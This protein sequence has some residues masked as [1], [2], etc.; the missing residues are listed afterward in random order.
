MSHGRKLV[1]RGTVLVD[2]RAAVAKLRSYQL[3]EPV[4][5]VLELVRAAVAGGATAIE[6]ENDADD[7]ALTF[8]G[9]AL[10]AEDLSRLLDFLLSES[11]RRLRLVAV[12]VNTALGFSPR[13]VD[14]YTT[15]FEGAPADASTVARVR[16]SPRAQPDAS[17]DQGVITRVA[18]P[19]GMPAAGMR[20][21]VREA[22]G[23]A[24]LREWFRAAPAETDLLR[25]RVVALPVPLTRN[26]VALTSRDAK[27][28]LASVA[29]EL[30]G[31]LRGTLEL[32]EVGH[33]RS[34][35]LVFCERGVALEIVP[36]REA[37]PKVGAP[38]LRM[39]VDADALPTNAS[40]SKVTLSAGLRGATRRAWEVAVTALIEGAIAH[41]DDRSTAIAESLAALLRF[42]A[43]EQWTS[44]SP[45]S[46]SEESEAVGAL[47]VAAVAMLLNAPIVPVANG[48]R[49][50]LRELIA[51][52]PRYLWNSAKPPPEE[53]SPWLRGVVWVRGERP[54]LMALLAAVEMEPASSAI[55]RAKEARSRHQRFM[56]LPAGDPVNE[57]RE[58]AIRLSFGEVGRARGE[59]TITAKGLAKP[60]AMRVV[61]WI[62]RRP[63][64]AE[65]LDGSPVAC[66]VA[67]EAPGLRAK[68]EFD[69]VVRDAA[70][71]DAV[72]LLRDLL[73]E[74][75][76]ALVDH[77][78]GA[79]RA[80]D[81]RSAWIGTFAD[82]VAPA[83]RARVV[84]AAWAVALSRVEPAKRRA[85][86]T[87]VIEKHPRLDTAP[88]WPT[89]SPD[90]TLDT[91]TVRKLAS[92]P[93]SVILSAPLLSTGAHP[94]GTPVLTLDGDDRAT[95]TQLV[96]QRVEW[97]DY[98][99]FL[100]PIA[101]RPL[102]EMLS[103]ESLATLPWV[104]L[105]RD[106]AR[107]A[108]APAPQAGRGA[109]TLVHA[110][111]VLESRAHTTTISRF[112]LTT[113]LAPALVVLE[114]DGI[115]PSPKGNG[116]VAGTLSVEAQELLDRAGAALARGL[117]AALRGERGSPKLGDDARV[118]LSALRFILR[119]LKAT[120]GAADHRDLGDAITSAPL[121]P[122]FG[123]GDVETLVS[124]NALTDRYAAGKGPLPS[125]ATTPTGVDGAGF[126]AIILPPDIASAFSAAT[127]VPLVDASSQLPHRKG[128]RSRRLAREALLAR[129]KTNLDALSSLGAAGPVATASLDRAGSVAMAP[130]NG[131]SATRVQV[132]FNDV[133]AI[134]RA[135]VR[136]SYPVVARVA[137]SQ[138]RHLR[139]SFDSLTTAGVQAVEKLLEAGAHALASRLAAAAHEG[140]VG[141]ASRQFLTSWVGLKGRRGL[142]EDPTLQLALAR[143]PL[144]RTPTGERVALEGIAP[145]ISC[146]RVT[147]GE[148]LGP[149]PGEP[150]DPVYLC[151]ADEAWVKCIASISAAA[152]R[153]VTQAALTSQR[154]RRLRARGTERIHLDGAPPAP[155][156]SGRIESLA[157]SLGFGELRIVEGAPGVEVSVFVEGR[158][159]HRTTLRAPFAMA[160]AIECA[161]IDPARVNESFL[162]LDPV[163]KLL[164]AARAL[165]E[166]AAAMT[167]D[168]IPAWAQ[169]CLRW[170]LL[171]TPGHDA[172]ARAAAAF[173]DSA[174]R[175]M[176]LDDFEAQSRRHDAVAFAT[177]A[178]AEPVEPTEPDRRVV[179]LTAEEA[180][181]LGERWTALN[182][183]SRLFE[184]AAARRWDAERPRDKIRATDLPLG[185]VHVTFDDDEMEGEIG[186]FPP[187]VEGRA[188]VQWFSLRRPLCE[189]DLDAPWPCAVAVE[190]RG[191][192]PNRSR[193]GPAEGDA[194]RRAKDVLS[195]RIVRALDEAR[196]APSDALATAYAHDTSSPG[197]ARSGPR[198]AGALWLSLDDRAG[199]LDVIADGWRG[200]LGRDRDARF[201]TPVHGRLWVRSGAARAPAEREA[202]LAKVVEWAWQSMLEALIVRAH[203]EDGF[204]RDDRVVD[205]LVRG[206]LRGMLSGPKAR[207][208]ARTATLPGSG[209]TYERVAGSK[210]SRLQLVA[211]GDPRIG[212]PDAVPDLDT[213]WMQT[214][215]DDD[216]LRAAPVEAAE[217]VAKP[218]R[219]ATAAPAQPT[220]PVKSAPE[221]PEARWKLGAMVRA[222]LDG[223]R[224]AALAGVRVVG[225]DDAVSAR[226]PMV[227]FNA[228][229]N[230]VT[231]FRA[232]P[233]V[234]ALEA[235]PAQRAARFLAL[236]SFGAINRDRGKITDA[237][238][239]AFMESLLRQIA[240][241]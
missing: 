229:A 121:I 35:A 3:G 218:S 175:P 168:A 38:P 215:R 63:L 1:S 11:N 227:R 123:A 179:L 51:W 47:P 86:A 14:L 136:T 225:A 54:A 119:T 21:H 44:W 87:A 170:W 152:A 6:L 173:L 221:S 40:R 10:D 172:R 7:F 36:L 146:V 174:G 142:H 143:A 46:A 157:P 80:D 85:A 214:L 9:D 113:P 135:E 89:T 42:E 199:D 95:L 56:S 162:Q 153:D 66:E 107:L 23:L 184:D 137:L 158:K 67:I 115:I 96:P 31:D 102:V 12:A 27:P 222:L 212:G 145:P 232:H 73:F 149:S 75:L 241:E 41:I 234:M 213:P 178:P 219:A 140:D 206:A 43:G 144:W 62:E 238:E 110:G 17:A 109:L 53:L 76:A 231:V 28:P 185:A 116:A 183:T 22:F 203:K 127:G 177:G 114:D 120:E 187:N 91:A 126:D 64:G 139:S 131:T 171:T 82:D 164:S 118:R 72:T 70:F 210:W 18:R 155:A 239:A 148:W 50:S 161:A 103:D 61:P 55:A 165:L 204:T 209:V 217:P 202:L 138:E 117:V 20:V 37:R 26:G 181:W 163:P 190:A 45:T 68:P 16:W 211:P 180:R 83:V 124:I 112:G 93:P 98:K 224:V 192:A 134:D 48:A 228:S 156:L 154:A 65:S 233:T 71:D 60:G 59:L 33:P 101:R 230:A 97:V 30:S 58:A 167:R 122:V 15:R 39:I 57:P 88:A 196:P 223:A 141:E 84:R 194:L 208:W 8:D 226:R 220:Q 104:N 237:D 49:T 169:P 81:P 133:V 186:L 197:D 188:R 198:V 77:W 216:R 24:V 182:Y 100:T 5:Y 235:G 189:L 150:A 125:L 151:V 128:E 32:L 193:S 147:P 200:H 108:I 92:L 129:A 160:V 29:L 159:V 176:C 130:A 94:G 79:L 34:G 69:G 4:M 191:V 90:R 207:T 166:R 105:K 78:E 52:R 111:R 19:Q 201:D 106:G 25:E 99:P 132:L 236:A 74:A 13:Y 240:E 205:H 2:P 195:R